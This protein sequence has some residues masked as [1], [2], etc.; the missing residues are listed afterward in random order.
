MIENGLKLS[1]KEEE[2]KLRGLKA[3]LTFRTIQSN[4]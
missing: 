3:I 2:N 1:W 4:S